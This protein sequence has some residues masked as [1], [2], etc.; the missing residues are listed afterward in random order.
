MGPR[1]YEV[2][3]RD[4]AESVLVGSASLQGGD[5]ATTRIKKKAAVEQEPV[6]ALPGYDQIAVRAYEIHESGDGG[7]PVYNWLR[8]EE[9]LQSVG[10]GAGETA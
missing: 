7:D 1:R 5:M 9:E 3:I 10:G 4:E 6:E 8:A 2:P